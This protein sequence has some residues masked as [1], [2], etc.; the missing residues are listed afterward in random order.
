MKH[1]N[2]FEAYRIAQKFHEIKGL[3]RSEARGYLQQYIRDALRE[4]LLIQKGFIIPIKISN[5]K[6]QTLVNALEA[7]QVRCF[8]GDDKCNMDAK[9]L[10]EWDKMIGHLNQF[11]IFFADECKNAA[12][13][14]VSEIGLYD[15]NKLIESADED[16]SSDMRSIMPARTLDEWKQAGK[17]LAFGLP[18]AC[19]YHVFRAVEYCLEKYF[20]S[21]IPGPFKDKPTWGM[22]HSELAKING[23]EKPDITVL[24]DL[25][26]MT[27]VYRN[28][29]IH[30]R[31]N[32]LN[33]EEARI[34]YCK[35]YS[36]IA[37]MIPDMKK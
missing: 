8:T 2:L 29:L 30:L 18:T 10:T 27:D 11:E 33:M 3:G 13:Y 9:Q 35:G 4:I 34:I 14:L 28:P 12:T 21:W 26:Q 1:I 7:V 24:R 25:H 6:C 36:L 20:Q 5:E 16:F 37:S 17:C 23:D 19:G 22:Y 32:H 31:M 15:T